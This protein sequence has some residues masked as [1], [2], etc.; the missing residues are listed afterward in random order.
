MASFTPESSHIVLFDHNIHFKW[1]LFTPEKGW[2]LTFT[3]IEC[4]LTRW[5]LA[6]IS[7]ENG[8]IHNRTAETD[9]KSDDKQA[10]IE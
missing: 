1:M 6:A 5:L 8:N 4:L 2:L 7:K 3:V 9:E 10:I